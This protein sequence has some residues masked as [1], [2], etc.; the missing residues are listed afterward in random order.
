MPLELRIAR[1]PYELGQI[2]WLLASV[3]EIGVQSVQALGAYAMCE[4][5]FGMTADV[6]FDVRPASVLIA[7]F[8][9]SGADRQKPAQCL[10]LTQRLLRGSLVGFGPP[11]CRSKL[12][13]DATDAKPGCAE[14]C[15]L[16]RVGDVVSFGPFKWP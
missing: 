7:N 6:R 8:L 1:K 10:D 2:S 9:A 16:N 14:Q 5:G 12:L 3:L 13:S 11:A 15:D 4:V